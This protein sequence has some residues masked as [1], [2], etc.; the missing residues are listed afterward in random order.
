[1][2]IV[3]AKAV[4][5]GEALDPSFKEYAAQVL[6]NAKAMEQ[7]FKERGIDMVSGGTDSHLILLDLRSKGL[8]GKEVCD[9]LAR[10]HIICNKNAVPND[11]Q[12]PTITSGLR[13]GTAAGTTRG[14]GEEEFKKIAHMI[15]D[16]C[17]ALVAKVEE[18]IE[19]EQKIIDKVNEIV[20]LFPIYR[21][22]SNMVAEF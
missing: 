14:F 9:A 4:A 10:V 5:L 17:D 1:M 18:N 3:A 12:K 21:S 16:V 15:A 11:P 8:T 13:V 19:W 6:K 2:H 7:V 20:R 22:L